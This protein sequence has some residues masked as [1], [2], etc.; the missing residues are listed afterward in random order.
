LGTSVAVPIL[1]PTPSG[2]NASNHCVAVDAGIIMGSIFGAIFI[3]VVVVWILRTVE[4]EAVGVQ[5]DA[6]VMGSRK[7]CMA[8]PS[9]A[10]GA[11]I[12]DWT[13]QSG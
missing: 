2:K 8:P 7:L 5:E 1:F 4:K 9:L 12:K 6:M 10:D 13:G 11:S 3:C